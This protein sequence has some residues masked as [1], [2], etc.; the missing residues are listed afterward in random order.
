MSDV[1]ATLN[2]TKVKRRRRSHLSRE[3]CLVVFERFA[4]TVQ[5]QAES[6]GGQVF[7]NAP[8]GQIDVVF[9]VLGSF[10]VADDMFEAIRVLAGYKLPA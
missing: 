2:S 7:G 8:S 4:K 5:R 1:R 10:G 6:S 9:R 3:D